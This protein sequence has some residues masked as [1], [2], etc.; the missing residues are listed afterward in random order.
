MESTQ[1]TLAFAHR[2]EEPPGLAFR[3]RL[4]YDSLVGSLSLFQAKVPSTPFALCHTCQAR[5]T[6]CEQGFQAPQVLRASDLDLD[7]RVRC[8]ESENIRKRQAF[9]LQ[10]K[11]NSLSTP[12]SLSARCLAGMQPSDPFSPDKGF[13]LAPFSWKVSPDPSLEISATQSHGYHPTEGHGPSTA[14]PSQCAPGTCG[15]LCVGR[16]VQSSRPLVSGAVWHSD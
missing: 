1:H 4:D 10:K 15:V 16:G 5:V 11:K 8:I 14:Q 2:Q 6:G 3:F 12:N 9:F 7:H 13:D